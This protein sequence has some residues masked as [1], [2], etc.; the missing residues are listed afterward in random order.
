MAEFLS[1]TC[2]QFLKIVPLK[3]ISTLISFSTQGFDLV[4]RILQFE[5]SLH[6]TKILNK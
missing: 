2:L 6:K 5:Y 3:M 1:I 4:D